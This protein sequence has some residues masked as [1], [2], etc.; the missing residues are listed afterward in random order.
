MIRCIAIDD[1]PLALAQIRAYISKIPFLELVAACGSAAEAQAVMQTQSVE[2]MFVDINM[3]DMNGMEFVRSIAEPER[4]MI[5]FTTAYAEY[6]VDGFRLDAIDYLLKPFGLDE[7][8]HAADKALSLSELRRRDTQPDSEADPT[9][10]GHEYIS[11]K[12]DH[13]VALVRVADIVYIESDS[14]Y[15]RLVLEDGSRIMTLFRLKNMEATL[16]SE[17]FMRIHR[18]Y[19]VNLRR[20][21][22]YAKGRV[23]LGDDEYLPIGENYREA[24]Q[25]YVEKLFPSALQ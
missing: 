1:E 12:A 24:F 20:I 22:G 9:D 2:L 5:I 21:K 15:V 23:Y 7:F 17:M 8:R 4:P 18:S 10:T 6:A 11:V 14:E 25:S 16:P 19:I 3:P 13:K